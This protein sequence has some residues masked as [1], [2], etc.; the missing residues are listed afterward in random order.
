MDG[1]GVSGGEAPGL[2]WAWG[3]GSAPT[4]PEAARFPAAGCVT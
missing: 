2:G 1:P 4:G 3:R